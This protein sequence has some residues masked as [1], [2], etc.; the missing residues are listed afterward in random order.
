MAKRKASILDDFQDLFVA[1]RW[2]VG[3]LL[4]GAVY[5]LFRFVLPPLLQRIPNGGGN[6]AAAAVNKSLLNALPPVL[7][8]LAP[9][10]AGVV[11]LVWLVS[12]LK[13]WERRVILNKTRGLD[14][15]RSLPWEQF[16]LLVGEYYRR[17]GFLVVE[18]GGASPDGGIDLVLRK[19]GK[20]TLVQCKHWKTLKVGVRVVRELLGVI[21]HER[22]DGGVLVTS[23]EFTADAISLARENQVELVNGGVLVKMLHAVQ[24]VAGNT[25]TKP[26]KRPPQSPLEVGGGVPCAPSCPKCGESMVLRTAKNGPNAG[27]QF[28]G[29]RRYPE[30]RGIRNAAVHIT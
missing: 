9:W 28:Y 21:T 15:V 14:G 6:T 7:E 2:W 12:L 13:K 29:C 19:D 30:C 27:S 18:R 11:L 24:D 22:A 23:G 17:R 4:V 1:V 25:S 16:E 26:A 20:V 10:I 8:R 3:L 5:G